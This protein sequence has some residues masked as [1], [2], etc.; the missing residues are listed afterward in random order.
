MILFALAG[1]SAVPEMEE[2]LRQRHPKLKKAI[3]WGSLIPLF[4]YLFFTWAIVGICGLQASDD[5]IS[6]LLPFLPSW[7][8]SLGA[9]LGVLTMGTSFLALGY[10]LREVWY[11]DYKLSKEA[12]LVLA[13]FPSLI[14]FLLGAK[15]FIAVLETTGALTGGLTGILII[16]LYRRALKKGQ[17][18]PAYHLRVPSAILWVLGVV[19]LL[20]MFSPWL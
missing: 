20:G 19:F 10:V 18:E 13:C 1:S 17:R 15:N 14:L 9:A 4:T 11:R 8:V 16:L 2:V 5:A 12:A 7:V 6:G 3:V